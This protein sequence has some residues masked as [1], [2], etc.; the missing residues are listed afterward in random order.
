MLLETENPEKVTEVPVSIS[1]FKI[2]RGRARTH[3]FIHTETHHTHT[4]SGF[5]TN[6]TGS[7][8]LQVRAAK[9]PGDSSPYS[10]T[11]KGFTGETQKLVA[12]LGETPGPGRS[13]SPRSSTPA[14]ALF[15]LRPI[16]PAGQSRRG[17]GIYPRPPP[18]H[19]YTRPAPTPPLSAKVPGP[20]RSRRPPPWEQG[21][22]RPARC[23]GGAAAPAE[24]G[25]PL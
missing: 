9:R 10:S 2:R 4:P 12:E 3:T 18:L 6:Q 7:W 25:C 22:H 15:L 11:H 8:R 16:L 24:H 19:T 20:S 5:A 23:F 1:L 21:H 17:Q 13:S 14:P